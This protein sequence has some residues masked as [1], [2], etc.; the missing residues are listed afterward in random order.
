MITAT[1]SDIPAD[2][3]SRVDSD[4][5]IAGS[6]AVLGLGLL[7]LGLVRALF[8]PTFAVEIRSWSTL[9]M[10]VVLQALPFLALGVVVSGLVAVFLSPTVLNR[11]VPK[12]VYLGVPAAALVGVA[13][14]G[15]ECASVPVSAR[16]MAQ[17]VPG[18]AALAFLVASPA[19]NPVVLIATAVA[20]PGQPKMVF[21]RFVASV[22]AA[23]VIGWVW[24]KWGT[25]PRVALPDERMLHE[26]RILRFASTAHHDLL[27][28]GSFLVIGAAATSTLQTLVPRSVIDQV[29]G[30]GALSVVALAL[31]AFVLAV[32]SEADA[33]VVA[34]LQGFPSPPDL[35]SSWS[36]QWSTSSSSRCMQAPSDE[37]S[38][39]VS[40]RSCS[41]LQSHLRL[42]YLR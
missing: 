40:G 7:A 27:H 33:F 2:L 29:A 19:I 28:A 15:C 12:N 17:G 42:S 20:F 18:P 16:L 32:C 22:I 13:L 25:A 10:A 8:A 11:I 5:L 26:R 21:A 1:H 6:T 23:T 31:L 36:G 30:L 34:G 35:P 3:E 9:F 37:N 14:P 39:R 38:P 4:P 41:S 24:A